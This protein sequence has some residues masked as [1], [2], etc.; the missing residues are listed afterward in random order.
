MGVD[1]L[2]RIEQRGG[3]LIGLPEY[4]RLQLDDLSRDRGS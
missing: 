2:M 1:A 3:K 4:L